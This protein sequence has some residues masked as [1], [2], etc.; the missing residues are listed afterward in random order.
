M[1]TP[2]LCQGNFII[3]LM[4]RTRNAS[5]RTVNKDCELLGKILRES[6]HIE[7]C[8]SGHENIAP[9]EIFVKRSSASVIFILYAYKDIPQYSS[10]F[11]GAEFLLVAIDLR[12][13]A[14]LLTFSFVEILQFFYL[15]MEGIKVAFGPK[16]HFQSLPRTTPSV[17]FFAPLQ[18]YV[19]MTM[20][21]SLSASTKFFHLVV[22]LQKI[23]EKFRISALSVD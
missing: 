10:N 1:I 15:P 6:K 12:R 2:L 22:C 9:V 8:I 11:N 21:L 19:P 23:P 3:R 20:I 18:P 17:V 13:M 14:A 7:T 4:S 5:P 16:I